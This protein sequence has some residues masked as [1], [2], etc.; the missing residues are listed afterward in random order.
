MEQLLLL[1]HRMALPIPVGEGAVALTRM[2]I[3]LSVMEGLEL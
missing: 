3:L 1:R 2:R